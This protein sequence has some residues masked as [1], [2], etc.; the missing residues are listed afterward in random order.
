MVAGERGW[1]W[2]GWRC[3]GRWAALRRRFA[4]DGT[5]DLAVLGAQ[6][7]GIVVEIAQQ[8]V[9]GIWVA[10]GA[11]AHQRCGAHAR[12]P[13]GLTFVDMADT[14]GGAGMPFGDVVAHGRPLFVTELEGN[15]AV[16]GIEPDHQLATTARRGIAVPR[17]LQARVILADKLGAD[18]LPGHI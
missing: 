12:A 18:L 8:P 10:T 5:D 17:R 13:R 4:E 15:D 9:G 1:T 6:R 7:G 14:R 2:R 11:E 3:A 16:L